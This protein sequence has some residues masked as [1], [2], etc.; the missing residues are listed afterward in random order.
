MVQRT[1]VL[2]FLLSISLM[3][4]CP[5]LST[6]ILFL[7]VMMNMSAMVIFPFSMLMLN[8]HV[9]MFLK[10]ILS[11]LNIFAASNI[12]SPVAYPSVSRSMMIS[13]SSIDCL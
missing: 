1:S 5:L 2:M 6:M 3:R 10:V 4:F 11:V 9:L 13:S 12:C 8:S 7:R